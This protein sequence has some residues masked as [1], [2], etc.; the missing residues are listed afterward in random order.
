MTAP[1]YK[2]L[3]VDDDDAICRCVT[4]RLN[5]IGH[6]CDCANCIE[7]ARRLLAENTYDYVILDMELPIEYGKLPDISTGVYFL[8]SLREKFPREKLPIIVITAKMIEGKNRDLA[9]KI[10]YREATDLLMKPLETTGEH[11]IESSIRKFV[12][13]KKDGTPAVERS[14]EWLFR[15]FDE[16]NDKIMVWRTVAKNGTER[17]YPIEINSIRGRLLDCVNKMRF[18]NPVICHMDLMTA[19]NVWTSASYY[20][21]DGG[22]PRGPLKSHVAAFRRELGIKITYVEN[23]ITVEQPEE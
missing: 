3:V 18:K 1:L 12:E 10:F 23:G 20:A 13:K 19:S 8:S 15:D 9:S 14:S 21:K 5:A 17:R 2:A 11:T 6:D 7:D 4:Q 22:A 16:N